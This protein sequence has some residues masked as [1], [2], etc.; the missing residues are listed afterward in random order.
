MNFRII[1][2][3]ENNRK[4]LM[5]KL[6]FRKYLFDTD[7]L[8]IRIYYIMITVANL[9]N[10]IF[11][12]YQEEHVPITQWINKVENARYVIVPD[13]GVLFYQDRDLPA[14]RPSSKSTHI[15]LCGVTEDS[16]R[17]GVASSMFRSMLANGCHDVIS[18]HVNRKKFPEMV[19]F[20]E[21]LGFQSCGQV[22]DKNLERFEILAVDL[23]HALYKYS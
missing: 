14:Y 12:K 8:F 6:L 2:L 13:R 4:A 1:F 10:I 7:N 18:T 23:K 15:W 21:K 17:I 3:L 22:G 20:L 19:T 11:S 16:R 9:T 5:A